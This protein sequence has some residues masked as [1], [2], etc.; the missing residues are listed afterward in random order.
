MDPAMIHIYLVNQKINVNVGNQKHDTKES[1]N[2]Q[3]EPS[4]IRSTKTKSP[5]RKNLKDPYQ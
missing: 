5:T 1:F 4:P 2:K 3:S